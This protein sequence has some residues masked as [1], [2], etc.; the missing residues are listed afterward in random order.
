MY[1]AINQASIVISM[2]ALLA[3]APLRTSEAGASPPVV[4]WDN[5]GPHAAKHTHEWWP[6][7]AL[8]MRVLMPSGIIQDFN[9]YDLASDIY[10]PIDSAEPGVVDDQPSVVL[11]T[12]GTTVVLGLRSRTIPITLPVCKRND[13]VGLIE[14]NDGPMVRHH[15]LIMTY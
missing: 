6:D 7:D 10:A 13:V 5:W 14:R 4:T 9:Q 1:S 12:A 11:T 8:G 3:R 2:T 15:R